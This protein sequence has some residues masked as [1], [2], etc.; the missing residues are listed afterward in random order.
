[1]SSAKS[2]RAR[3]KKSRARASKK[4]YDPDHHRWRKV[5]AT[6]LSILFFVPFTISFYVQGAWFVWS[7]VASIVLLL[8][9][10]NVLLEWHVWKRK[11]MLGRLALL[12]ICSV[13]IMGG[14]KWQSRIRV[15]PTRRPW[16]RITDEE[17]REF[18]ASLASQTEPREHVRLGCP[19]ANEDIC[20]LAAPFLDAFKRGHFFVENDQMY[21]VTLSKP[22]SGVILSSYGHADAFDPQDPDQGKW[23]HQTASLDTIEDAFAA[24]GI[25]AGGSADESLP[26]DVI[27]VHFGIE[28]DERVDKQRELRRKQ[29]QQAEEEIRH[30]QTP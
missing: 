13:L 25:N 2:K 1:M 16:L 7:V 9:L 19:A 28:P 27:S 4:R 17:M 29:K 11:S 30:Q 23:V 3:Q 22:T 5:A 20:V 12:V 10:A 6:L 15:P 8:C 18:V 21:R 14:F 26:K 24:I